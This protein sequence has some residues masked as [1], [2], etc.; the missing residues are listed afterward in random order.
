MLWKDWKDDTGKWQPSPQTEP[1]FL[2]FHNLRPPSLFLSP[3]P[4]EF[5]GEKH[6]SFTTAASC[7]F[8]APSPSCLSLSQADFPSVIASNL[9]CSPIS[10]SPCCGCTFRAFPQNFPL[11]E[12]TLLSSPS[13]WPEDTAFIIERFTAAKWLSINPSGQA[14]SKETRASHWA[15][16]G[17]C[18]TQAQTQLSEK[19]IITLMKYSCISCSTS[20]YQSM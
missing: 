19:V 17:L 10:S 9:L 8:P 14:E 2:W 7:F 20:Y 1:W 12:S 4:K 5:E 18:Q 13:P 3:E 16:K 15:R 11:E 6:G